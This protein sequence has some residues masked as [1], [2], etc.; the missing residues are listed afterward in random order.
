MRKKMIPWLFLAPSL[1]GVMVFMGIP[2]LDVVRRS[3]LNA[4]GTT[5]LGWDNY[6]AV[7]NNEAFRLAAGNTLHFLAVCSPALMAVSRTKRF[8]PSKSLSSFKLAVV[9]IFMALPSSAP[10]PL[11]LMIKSTYFWPG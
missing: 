8:K 4:M 6:R 1:S 11:K 5:F 3:F 7:W 10:Q 9:K 2:F